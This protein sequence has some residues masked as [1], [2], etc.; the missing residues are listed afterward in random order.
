MKLI[1]L[2][3][4]IATHVPG[5]YSAERGATGGSI[6]PRY[7]Y[8]VWMRHLTLANARAQ[9]GIPRVVAE[10][11]PGDSLG[12]GLCALLSGVDRFLAFDVV[13][14]ANA[15]TNRDVF[16]QLREL[17]ARRAPIPDAS[18]FPDVRPV[19]GNYSFPHQLL[20][21]QVLER[22]LA[23]ARLA[24][25]DEALAGQAG[26][27]Q[28]FEYMVPWHE[29]SVTQSSSVDFI[30]SQ[31]VLEHVDDLPATY[32]AL[33]RWLKPG[34]LMSHAI[35]FRSHKLTPGWDGHL[36]YGARSWE[37]VR[38]RRPYLL[39]RQPLALHLQ[40]LQQNGFDVVECTRERRAPTLSSR[41][42]APQ[43]RSW[44]EEDRTSAGAHL[45]ARLTRS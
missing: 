3:K 41:Q 14:Y 11:G 15:A 39:N 35:D 13:R 12:V 25:I 9:L 42:L 45:I 27:G 10:L 29:G 22:S 7:C 37:W 4:G 17:F 30:Y 1:P 33:A 8:T 23:P 20:T 2:L 31:A 24:G 38:G 43:F 28:Y 44:S 6:D 40:L 34:G 18:E 16:A 26:N 19:P 32:A 21:E 5:L 36:G